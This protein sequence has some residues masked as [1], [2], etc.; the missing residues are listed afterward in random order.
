M[1]RL[2][3]LAV[4]LIAFTANAQ[5]R[6]GP[7]ELHINSK[8]GVYAIGDTLRVW[9]DIQQGAAD[10]L[11][12]II[13]ENMSKYTARRKIAVRQGRQ[14]IHEEVC[15]RPVN[16]VFGVG[17]PG[18]ISDRPDMEDKSLIGVIVAPESFSP[19]YACPKDLKQFWKKQIRQMRRH[20]A[21]VT[22]KK[23]PE[24]KE[25]QEGLICQD[26]EISMHEGNPARGY[27]A[28][29]AD[30]EKG[31][32]PI[33]IMAHGAGVKG[34]WCQ[35]SIDE[36]VRNARIGKGA[37]S[38]DINAHGM[39]NG[40]PQEYYDALD[41]GELRN[42]SKWEVKDHE[43]FYFRLMYLRLV[44]ALD[45]LTSLP[46]WDGKRVLIYGESQGGAQASALA[47]MDPR[48]TAAVLRVP[49]FVDNGG[50][51]DGGRRGS[52]PTTYAAEPEK[53]KEILPY[54]DGALLLGLTKAKLF[55]E[56]GLIDYTCPPA[57]VAAGF[58]NAASKDKT[59]L[60]FPYRPHN[61]GPM[62][63]DQQKR[64]TKEILSKREK[65][66]EEHLK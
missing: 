51:L 43:T 24:G 34:S 5:K 32:L 18:K 47:G 46:Q 30:A 44:R 52:W 40:Q 61:T 8:D 60:F 16:L 11:E 10:T 66:I 45:Y 58:N 37:I 13:Q 50:M 27:V 59:I 14:M 39:L 7:A 6:Y 38:M 42:Y 56:A 54:Y 48:V 33:I 49:A 2:G 55:V 21:V 28:Y 19:G 22:G 12:F 31:S 62:T 64:W 1:K 53:H 3:L 25:N 9:A 4:L 35:S 23:A 57:C 17:V 29:P 36:A 20:K 63:R 65:F 26:V 15:D 41:A